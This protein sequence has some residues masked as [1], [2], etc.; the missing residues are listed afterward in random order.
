MTVMLLTEQHLEFLCLKGGC[1]DSSESTLVKMLI[2]LEI[3]CRGS[4]MLGEE[5]V[6]RRVKS[7]MFYIKSA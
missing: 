6:D 2:F 5:V 1:T 7:T 3:T 4:Y